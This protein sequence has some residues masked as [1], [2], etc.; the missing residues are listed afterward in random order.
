MTLGFAPEKN[1]HWPLER[2]RPIRAEREDAR[3]RPG[4]AHHRQG[5]EFGWTVPVLVADA[6]EVIAGH[7]R[8]LAPTELGLSE[9]PVIVLGQLTEAQRRAYRIADNRLT[10]LGGGM[11]L[12]SR[13][14]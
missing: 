8:I 1:E 10:E 14:S 13:P 6:G 7:G 2:L 5:R 9:A 12:C 3:S 11:T 4:I